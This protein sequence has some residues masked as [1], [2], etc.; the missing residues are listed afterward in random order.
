MPSPI[1]CTIPPATAFKK[2]TRLPDRA[3]GEQQHGYPFKPERLPEAPL[4][5]LPGEEFDEP[6][7]R[8]A[9]GDDDLMSQDIDAIAPEMPS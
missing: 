6:A 4:A 8:A 7:R 3:P 2:F 9:L 1:Q 5:T